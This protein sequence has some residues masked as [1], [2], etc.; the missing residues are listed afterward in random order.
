MKV[1]SLL[2]V[3]EG[4]SIDQFR[5][6]INRKNVSFSQFILMIRKRIIIP[7]L[8][9]CE[10]E[11]PGSY[12]LVID[13]YVQ[14]EQSTRT[15]TNRRSTSTELSTSIAMAPRWLRSNNTHNIKK[16]CYKAK[17]LRKTPQRYKE[18]SVIARIRECNLPMGL[19]AK[20]KSKR[21][22]GVTCANCGR[23]TTDFCLGCRVYY[24]TTVPLKGGKTI[25]NN[26][27]GINANEIKLGFDSKSR[28]KLLSDERKDEQK[29]VCSCFS[30]A[31]V[32]C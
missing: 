16:V 7:I 10:M 20:T 32:H 31:H 29:Y 27:F 22:Q 24:C 1:Y 8:R 6:R 30:L 26:F 2:L 5:N 28:R 11:E 15:T 13:E 19:T 3:Q 25:L 17:P 14:L 9:K 12:R 18:S 21:Q 4:E 23:L